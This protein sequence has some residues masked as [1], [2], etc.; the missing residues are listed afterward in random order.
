MPTPCS[1]CGLLGCTIIPGRQDATI[2]FCFGS[3]VA[4]RPDI[5][6]VW[7]LA[8]GRGYH[9]GVPSAAWT[10]RGELRMQEEIVRAH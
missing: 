8:A 9:A 7:E 1:A 2:T 6:Q 3:G 4:R 5:R 10:G